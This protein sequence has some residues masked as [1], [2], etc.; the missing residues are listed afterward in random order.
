MVREGLSF[1]E[2]LEAA[3][4][5]Y[6][7]IDGQKIRLSDESVAEFR[8]KFVTNYQKKVVNNLE[9]RGV[10]V[11]WI[12]KCPTRI[13]LGSFSNQYCFMRAGKVQSLISDFAF[14]GCD[15]DDG[16]YLELK[17]G[18]TWEQVYDKL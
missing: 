11:Q 18:A 7:K 8:D 10:F 13:T 16:F 15:L 3:M 12:K 4:K 17:E 1:L 9:A 5:N 6:I 2:L 14:F